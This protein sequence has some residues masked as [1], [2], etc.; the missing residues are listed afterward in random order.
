MGRIE[1]K[2]KRLKRKRKEFERT[3][4]IRNH[5]VSDV[6]SHYERTLARERTKLF[7]KHFG[8]ERD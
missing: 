6:G 2:E 3:G 8:K 5:N 4:K 7:E 1:R